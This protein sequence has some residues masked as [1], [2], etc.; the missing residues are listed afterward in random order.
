MFGS[1]AILTTIILISVSACSK[2][3]A[4]STSYLWQNVTIGASYPQSYNYPVF[5]M[6]GE[7][8]AFNH[9]AWI[10]KDG[11][12]WTKTNLPDSGLN[13]AYQRFAQ[14]DGAVYAL[15]SMRGNY[16]D[17]TISPRILRT[18]DGR[19]WETLSEQSNL[20]KRIFY[21][22]A[23]FRN[24]IWLIAGYDGKNYLNDVWNSEDGVKWER[25][26]EKAPWSP[27]QGATLVLFKNRLW[28]FGGGV[29]DGEKEINPESHK[30][31]WTTEDGIN[32]SQEKMRTERAGGGTPIVFD[33]K[34]W[35]VGANR[36]DGNFDN[37]VAVSEDGVSWQSH[38]APWSP[39]GGVAVWVVDNKLF[40]TGG[41]YS[42]RE[43]NGEIKFVYSNDVWVMSKSFTS[44]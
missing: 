17:F 5:V 9:G 1:K 41:K 31:V 2:S 35:F 43:S 3:A 6:N 42:Y 29:I 24:K 19:S 28:L 20:P 34:L 40:M 37:A 7:M 44:G 16:E 33:D 39:R 15:G 4:E 12:N 25:V 21:S 8:L 36:N 11:R 23:V 32:W 27:R 18:R 38:S 26:V 10:S 13:S 30:E 22:T 14:F